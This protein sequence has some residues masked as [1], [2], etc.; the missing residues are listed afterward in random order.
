VFVEADKDKSQEKAPAA[1][2]AMESLVLVTS[3][4]VGELRESGRGRAAE[5]RKRETGSQ[6]SEA[7]F[8]NLK[9]MNR[10]QLKRP[11]STK[12]PTE[13]YCV[14]ILH[15]EDSPYD[16]AL[17]LDLLEGELACAITHALNRAEFESAIEQQRFD[18]ILCD[19]KVPGY[20]GF[21]ALEFAKTLQPDVPVIMISGAL[22]D[23]QA[24]QSL[25]HGATD[26]ILKE[27]LARLVPAIRRALDEADDRVIKAAAEERIREQASLLDLM[28]DAVLVRN[29][30]DE[31]VY[32]NP[33]A[34]TLFGWSAEEA[35]GQDFVGLLHGDP[36]RL[37]I[38]KESLLRSGDWLGEIQLRTRT[39][40]ERTVMSRWNLVRGKDGRPQ[41]ILSTNTDVTE[42]KKSDAAMFR[43]LAL[44][45]AEL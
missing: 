40:E 32:W 36:A 17:I 21:E 44:S 23:E 11:E 29:M 25:K 26:Y 42:W 43:P 35:V 14:Q 34:E 28:S 24:V 13:V 39:G 31:I 18:I 3:A 6:L 1:L 45:G 22:D 15:L 27:R 20:G 2:L 4:I 30:N 10:I 37:E 8:G 16:A 19:H 41:S 12:S 33:G 5:R 7:R 9:R 38:A